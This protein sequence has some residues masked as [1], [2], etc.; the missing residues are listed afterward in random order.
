MITVKIA[1]H[2]FSIDTTYLPI[3]ALF[4]DYL[5]PE[6]PE[7]TLSVSPEEIRA[8]RP[9][10][11]PESLSQQERLAIYRKLC[12]ALLADD[13]LLF[14]SSALAMDGKA[15]L[16]AAP[17][18]TGKSTHARLWREC[19]GGRVTMIND[20]KPLLKVR[21]DA[22][23]V[24]GTPYAGKEGLHA[25][26]SAP[27]AA[28]VLLRQGPENLIKPLSPGEAFPRLLDQAYRP[29][30]GAKLA[31]TLPLVRRLASLPVYALECTI[32]RAAAELVHTTLLK[33]GIL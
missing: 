2:V 9:D 4:R 7:F 24:Y 8:E 3:R 28:I 15:I 1:D 26:A 19:F 13:I 10:G 31:R 32:S 14:H 16:F 5:T 11:A 20:D 18:G 25:N 21:E 33:E 27:V 29:R 23:T 22:V 6:P 12:E 30:D 17:S